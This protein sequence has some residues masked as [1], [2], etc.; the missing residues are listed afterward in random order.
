MRGGTRQGAGRP[1]GT[2]RPSNLKMRSM[3]LTDKEYMLVKKYIESIRGVIVIGKLKKAQCIQCEGYG[4][5]GIDNDCKCHSCNGTGEIIDW[6][7]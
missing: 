2:T 6:E 1:L 7:D 5:Y 4:Y 3:R